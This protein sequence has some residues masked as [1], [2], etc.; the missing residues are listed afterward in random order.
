MNDPLEI[1]GDDPE[2][3]AD[4]MHRLLDFV[5][6]LLLP[7]VICMQTLGLDY[8]LAGLIARGLV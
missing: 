4:G 6:V 1:S 2:S 8:G 5:F 7:G 3:M